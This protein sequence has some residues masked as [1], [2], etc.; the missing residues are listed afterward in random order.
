MF[1]IE[2]EQLRKTYQLC[3]LGFMI[4]GMALVIASFSSL[5][6]LFARFEQ[7]QGLITWIHSSTWYQW[8]DTPM[9]WGCVIGA[10]LLWGRWDHAS[11]QRRAGLFLVM[12]LV[13]LGLW[14]LARGDAMG[15]EAPQRGWEFGHEWLRASLGTALGWG[16]FALISSLT[17]DYLS[18]LGVDHAR[19]S[20]KSTRSMAATGAMLWLLLFCQRTN[21][22]A[23]WP[24]QQHQIRGLEGILLFHGFHL[25]W[26]ITLI[27]VT[28]L[29]ISAV[30]QSTYVLEEMDREDGDNDLL[31][32]RSD[33]PQ[34]FEE[35]GAM[36]DDRRNKW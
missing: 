12:N 29:V 5:L 25:I 14:F 34:P 16:E 26:T 27:Q 3:R 9:V 13:D 22:R 8:I 10:I 33:L 15:A 17:C 6:E 30:R 20:D 4:L 11:W 35:V 19:D 2:R 21:W 31:R 36:R 24:L 32:S 7:G 23:G 18:H 1:D 28:A